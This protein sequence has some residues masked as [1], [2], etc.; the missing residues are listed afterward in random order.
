M[1]EKTRTKGTTMVYYTENGRLS[2]RT[3]ITTVYQKNKTNNK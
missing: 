1:T 2:K 3:P